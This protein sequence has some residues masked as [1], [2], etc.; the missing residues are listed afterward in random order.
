MVG[1]LCHGDKYHLG[2][3]RQDRFQYATQNK[4][5]YREY[6]N[7]SSSCGPIQ[8][9]F[10]FRSCSESD[11]HVARVSNQEMDEVRMT[12]QINTPIGRQS[13]THVRRKIVIFAFS[14]LC[15]SMANAQ[16]MEPA[17]YS[18][19]A[20]AIPAQTS[21]D[22][23][24]DHAMP[25]IGPRN[26][27]APKSID[28][29]GVTRT[30]LLYVPH[31]FEPGRSALILALHGRGD[32]GPGSVMEAYSHLDETADREGFAIAYLD[33]L[34]DATG[35][36]NWNYFYDPF[37]VSGPDD[38]SFARDV[39]DVLQETLHPDRRRIFVTGT[40]AG[41]FM[42]QRLGVE[43]SDRV[44]AIGVVE[45]GLFVTTPSTPQTVPDATAPVSVLFL[46][47]DQDP[48]NLYCGATFP[49]FGVVEA[50]SD[51]DFD[52]W[53]GSSADQCSRVDTQ[54]P[55]CE[56][57]GVETPTGTGTPGTPSSLVKKVGAGCRRD[58]EV[59]LYR[60]LGGVDQWNLKPMNIQGQVPF[61]PDLNF[62]TGV[63]TN[64]IL[65]KFFEQ[66]PK[67]DD[68]WNP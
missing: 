54:K 15:L 59:K 65:W 55:L 32:G 7:W 8:I 39:L 63:T 5:A 9:S 43:L 30:Y 57:V 40:S 45:G 33:G 18:A 68:G 67:L 38:V 35:T 62:R 21:A 31:T 2:T 14:V 10:R 13:R 19:E 36:V 52:Y 3:F 11:F 50:S 42:A 25:G 16:S 60:L 34:V 41:G 53:T 64:E 58:T 44:A 49:G 17:R 56:S 51:Q 1:W 37:F 24:A 4:V 6:G 20:Q 23:S 47:G 66:H 12:R 61:N 48:N 22:G 29:N 46:K 26:S 28:V 27:A